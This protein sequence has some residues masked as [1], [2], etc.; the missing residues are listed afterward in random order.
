MADKNHLHHRLMRLGHGQSR[1]VLILWTWT[2]LLSG[3]V[4]YPSFTSGG[5]SIVPFGI[6][7]LAI[8]LYTVFGVRGRGESAAAQTGR[9]QHEEPVP[10]ARPPR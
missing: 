5:L 6:A 8:A 10:A 3:L 1:S 9:E 7:A 2:A 4:L